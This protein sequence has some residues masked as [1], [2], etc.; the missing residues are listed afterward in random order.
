MNDCYICSKPAVAVWNLSANMASGVPDN[1]QPV[2]EEHNPY[3]F[4][5]IG[6]TELATLRAWREAAIQLL[7][8][9]VREVIMGDGDHQWCLLCDGTVAIIGMTLHHI[10][11]CP[12]TQARALL[13]ES[14]AS[15]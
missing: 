8:G 4:V 6:K 15:K 11:D 12:V 7:Q 5:I 10:T 3:Q 2:C 13:A 14:E 9:F 1:M